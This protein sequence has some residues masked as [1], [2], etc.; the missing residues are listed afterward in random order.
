VTNVTLGRAFPG[1]LFACH[2]NRKPGAAN[3][4]PV[5]LTP[6]DSIAKALTLKSCVPGERPAAVAPAGASERKDK[7]H[8]QP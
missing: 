8:E 6:W 1:G 3:G 5:L 2:T 4:R 7:N